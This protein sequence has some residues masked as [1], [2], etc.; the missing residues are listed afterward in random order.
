VLDIF[1]ERFQPMSWSGSRA[2]IMAS[3]IP[4]IEALATH[5]RPEV[6]EWSQKA[7]PA[8]EAAVEKAREHE[9][10]RDKERDERFE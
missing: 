1:M 8:F 10:A 7:L 6:S 4:L 2:D 9:A 3:R 5:E